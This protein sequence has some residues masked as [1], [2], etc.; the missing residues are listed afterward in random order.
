MNTQTKR[1]SW[2]R[3]GVRT[4]LAIVTVSSIGAGWI[5]WNLDDRRAESKAIAEFQEQGGSVIFHS[6]FKKDRSWL[7][8][9]GD[10]WFGEQAR[11]AELRNAKMIDMDNLGRMQELKCVALSFSEVSDVSSL[12]N[13]KNLDE[14]YL[15]GTNVEDISALAALPKLEMLWLDGTPVKDLS[16]LH[17]I[18]SLKWLKL[19]DT[20]LTNVDVEKLRH[21]LPNCDI[22]FSQRKTS[23]S[24]Q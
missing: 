13:L 2:R 8:R 5:A 17:Q 19:R 12:A 11:S 7:Q 18:K 24:G 6:F 16:P 9:Q 3:F 14:I 10:Y 15:E 21:A 22:V 23:T 1:R 20:Q 4:L